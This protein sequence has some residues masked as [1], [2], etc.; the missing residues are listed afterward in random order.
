MEMCNRDVMETRKYLAI[1]KEL[2]TARVD[3]DVPSSGS[4]LRKAA[5]DVMAAMDATKLMKSCPMLMQHIL[6]DCN[7]NIGAVQ[8]GA[9]SLA[10]DNLNGLFYPIYDEEK[11]G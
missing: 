8:W 7:S 3:V 4:S 5:I 11:M 6:G 10:Y 9:I 1:A 2:A